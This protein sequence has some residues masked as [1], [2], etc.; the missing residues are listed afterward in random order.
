MK[1]EGKRNTK[2]LVY[3]AAFI[4][5]Q[6][7]I[8]LAFA[9]TVMRV[10]SPKVRFGAVVV[11]NTSSSTNSS[12]FDMRLFAQVAIKNTNFGHFK[13]DSS[14]VTILYGDTQVGSAVIPKGRAKARKTQRFNVTIDV[15]SASLSGNANLA[16]DIGSGVLRLSSQAKLSGKVHLMKVIKKKKS[17]QMSC[18]IAVELAQRAIQELTCK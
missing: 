16:N 14:N 3:V 2:C 12:S 9:L 6:T 5:F 17:G 8:I 11:E 18:T 13:Y 4:V 1:G 10:K 15:T 7:I